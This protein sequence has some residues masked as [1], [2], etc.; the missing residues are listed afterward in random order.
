MIK[1]NYNNTQL[2][3]TGHTSHSKLIWNKNI[4]KKMYSPFYYRISNALKLLEFVLLFY[5]ILLL[6]L[7]YFYSL[8]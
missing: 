1:K 2:Y 7:F 4:N 6:L 8:T 5:F 3:W